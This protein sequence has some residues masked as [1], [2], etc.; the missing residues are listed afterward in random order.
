MVKIPEIK[1]KDG[2]KIPQLGFGTWKLFGQDVIGPLTTALDLGYNHIDTAERYENQKAIGE[3]LKNFNRKKVFITSKVWITKLSHDNVIDSCENTLRELQTDFIDLF[4]IHWPIKEISFKETLRAMEELK[5]NGKI[6]SIGVSNFAIKHL[7]DALN[8]GIE[9]VNNQVEFHP[10]LY[11]KELMEFCNKNKI[12]VTAYCPNARGEISSD[13]LIKSIGEKYQKS[14]A[15]VSLRWLVQKGIVIIPKS[16]N[17]I[18]IEENMRIF[19]WSLSKEDE[20]KID[21][22][23]NSKR[24]INPDFAD[25]D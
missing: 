12:S 9:F 11:Q 5:K 3:V 6:R 7:K 14:P 16:T 25:F 21:G 13:K 2:N 8:S 19:D 4:L 22:L 20:K 17:K 18:H 10:G 23:G 24:M 15:Q 1:L